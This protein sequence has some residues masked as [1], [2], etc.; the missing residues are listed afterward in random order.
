MNLA[1]RRAACA[2]VKLVFENGSYFI[3]FIQ[4]NHCAVAFDMRLSVLSQ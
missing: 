1:V 2:N 3:R 4:F